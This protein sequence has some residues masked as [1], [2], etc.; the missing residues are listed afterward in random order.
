MNEKIGQTS[1]SNIASKKTLGI[2]NCKH[3]GTIS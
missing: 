3:L 2:Y 1:N